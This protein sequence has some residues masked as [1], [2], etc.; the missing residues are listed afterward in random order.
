MKT[1]WEFEAFLKQFEEKS[2]QNIINN[3]TTAFKCHPGFPTMM[4]PVSQPAEVTLTEYKHHVCAVA[5]PVDRAQPETK[6]G[7]PVLYIDGD[8]RAK[9]HVTW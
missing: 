2:S 6:P 4:L 7:V 9:H 1:P 8:I 5:Q 3:N